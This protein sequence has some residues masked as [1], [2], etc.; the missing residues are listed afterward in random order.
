MVFRAIGTWICQIKKLSVVEIVRNALFQ[1]GKP[2]VLV[3]GHLVLDFVDTYLVAA[4]RLRGISAFCSS[5][6]VSIMGQKYLCVSTR[7]WMESIE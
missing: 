3:F 2:C 1:D 4:K 6:L 5:C 7:A